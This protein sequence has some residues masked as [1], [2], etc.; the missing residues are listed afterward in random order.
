MRRRVSGTLCMSDSFI[1]L[2]V[3]FLLFVLSRKYEKKVYNNKKKIQAK[4]GICRG[5][6]AVTKRDPHLFMLTIGVLYLKC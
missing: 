1:F 6:P 4:K 3:F 5:Y 2:S